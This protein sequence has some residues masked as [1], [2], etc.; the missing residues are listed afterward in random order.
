MDIMPVI[1]QIIMLMLLLGVGWFLRHRGVFTDPVIKAV[2]AL[3]MT[4]TWPA[5]MIS[6]T[7]KEY[8]PE[9][10][11]IFLYVL[12]GSIAIL[13]VA[14]ICVFFIYRKKDKNTAAVMA[15]LCAMPNAGFFGIPI[16]QALYG[17]MG[18]LYLSGYIVGFNIVLWTVGVTMYT[19]LNPQ[20]LKNLLNPGIVCAVLGIALFLLRIALPAPVLGTI[21]QLS[22]MNTPLSMLILGARIAQ[23][24]LSYLKDSRM[25]LS[26]FIKLVALPLLALLAFRL[27]GA[28]GMTLT[29]LVCCTAMPTA[30][31][32][33]MMTERY[34][35]DV[36]LSAK[37]TCVSTLCSAVTL[38]VMLM[39]T[40]WF[41]SR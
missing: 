39:V 12:V 1:D 2:N 21:N 33:Q 19:G 13:T 24:R 4:I 16:I 22:G 40:N 30:A 31:A 5:L 9:T 8:T 32:S 36:L 37:G 11:R 18:M 26:I 3:I 20:A 6:T 41:A 7:Q 29:I 23:L 38:P 35:G 27:I 25:W 17:D 14:L 15:M 10:L 34:G 28:T